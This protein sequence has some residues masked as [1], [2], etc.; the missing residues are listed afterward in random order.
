MRKNNGSGM[1]TLSEQVL[2]IRFRPNPEV[3]DHRGKWAQRLATELALQHWR[4]GKDRLDVFDRLD[5]ERVFISHFNLGFTCRNAPTQ[6]YFEEKANKFL[7]VFHELS[8]SPGTLFVNRIGVRLRAC[9]EFSGEFAE[10]VANFQERY[11][12]LAKDVLPTLRATVEDVGFFINY[13]DRMGYFN[14]MTGPMKQEQLR[15]Y[16]RQ[17]PEVA[18]ANNEDSETPY[19]E[20]GVYVDIDYWKEPNANMSRHELTEMTR[21]FVGACWAR[22]DQITSFIVGSNAEAQHAQAHT[23]S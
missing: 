7:R 11:A 17:S 22:Q 2:E 16:F 9:H 13:H 14:T 21:D 4:I 20:V 6:N 1:P 12:G 15:N 18:S 5:S 10:L 8:P 19:P 3:L 23:S